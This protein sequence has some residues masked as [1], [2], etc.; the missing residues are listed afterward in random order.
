MQNAAQPRLVLPAQLLKALGQ[1]F[2]NM[3]GYYLHGGRWKAVAKHS[4]APKG[5]PVAHDHAAHQAA[6]AKHLSDEEW[7][8]L[9]L[10]A[11]NTNSGHYN[12]QLDKLKEWSEAG[13]GAAILG[14]SF[15]TNTYGKKLATVANHLLGKMGSQHK[16]APGQKAG[17]HAAVQAPAEPTTGPSIAELQQDGHLPA[18]EAA[19]AAKRAQNPHAALNEETIP[20]AP[21]GLSSSAGPLVQAAHQAAMKGD[22]DK[23]DDLMMQVHEEFNGSSTIAHALLGHLHDIKTAMADKAEFNAGEPGP[24]DGD[25]K[26]GANGSTLTF[27]D[28]RWHAKD[29]EPAAAP[30]PAAAEPAEPAPAAGLAM[31]EFQEGKTVTGVVAYYQ[32]VAQQ[33]IDH[34]EAGNVAVLEDMKAMGLKPNAKGKVSNTWAGKTP[35]SK[36][37]LALHKQALAHANGGA[38]Q[39][40]QSGGA[41]SDGAGASQPSPA[42]AAPAAAAADQEPVKNETQ[43]ATKETE[44]VAPPA[45]EPVKNDTGPLTAQQ[46]Q[47][48]QSIP[49]HKLK[50]PDSNTNAAS[51]NKKLQALQ[52]AAFAGDV[53]AIEAMTWGKNT[54]NKKLEL[55]AQTAVAALKEGA[56]PA[57]APTPA[58]ADAELA[59]MV[60][61][62]QQAMASE[63]KP[64]AATEAAT[65][66]QELTDM[67]GQAGYGIFQHPNKGFMLANKQGS[68][69]TFANWTQA[70][71]AAA[72]L[73]GLGLDAEVIGTYPYL[74]KVHGKVTGGPV[75]QA[76]APAP[77]AS[78]GQA[79]V[80]P[81]DHLAGLFAQS[82]TIAPDAL[83]VFKMV[84]EGTPGDAATVGEAITEVQKAGY[85]ESG[86][87]MFE[88]AAKHFGKAGPQEG[89]TKTEDGK[90]YKLI[91]GRWHLVSAEGGAPAK[92]N[93][94]AGSTWADYM[95]EIDAAIADNNI[96]PMQAVLT[97][98][99]G[100]PS[101]QAQKLKAYAEAAIAYTTEKFN[102]ELNAAAPAPAPAEAKHPV[103]EVPMPDLSG[104]TNSNWKSYASTAIEKLKAE[105]KAGNTDVLKG[106]TKKMGS[107]NHIINMPHPTVAGAKFK[108]KGGGKGAQALYEYVEAV[109]AAMGKPAKKK[110]APKAQT[111]SPAQSYG[112]PEAMDSWTQT[113]GQGGS[114]PG[115][116]FKDHNG[117]EWYCKFPGDDDVAKSEVLAAKLYAAAGLASQDAKLITKDGKL[118][119]ASKW[120]NV[121]KAGG[122][123]ELAKVDGALSGFAVD[124]WLGNWDV[125]GMALDNLQVGPDGKAMRVDA[126]GSLEYRAQGAKKP[127]GNE[128]TEMETLL[129]PSKNPHSAAVFGKMTEADKIASVAKVLQISDVAIRALVNQ[130]GPGD[131]AAKQKLAETLIARKADLAKKYPQA[132]KAKKAVV[133]KPEDISAPPSFTN[134]GGSGKSGPSSKEFVNL[135]NE[136]AVQ[137]IFATAKLGS[138]EAV[139]K[140]K[141]KTYDKSTGAVSGEAPVLEHPSQ[142]VKGYAQQVVN[143]INYQ[144]NPP[145]KFR[146][147]GG[148][149]LKALD[150]AYPTSHGPVSSPAVQ[151]LGKYVVLGEPGTIKVEDLSL[152]PEIKHTSAGGTLTTGT[153]AKTAQAV[154]AKMPKT[155]LQAIQAY[156]GSSY[157]EMNGSLWSGNPS[158]A[159]KSAGEALKTLGHDIEPGTILSRK[160]KSLDK[161]T[162]DQLMNSV[163]KVIQEP[164]IM[165]TS[166]RPSSWH[167]VVHL[168]LRV[169]P[170][171]KGLYVGPGSMPGGGAI[172]VNASEDEI[173]LPPN[174]RMLV[175]KASKGAQDKDGFGPGG[176]PIIECVILPT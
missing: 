65:K 48:L 47:A 49:W 57:P 130:F 170:G 44:P 66:L 27:K 24:K 135:A 167:G 162:I 76:P 152:P 1:K 77:E 39:P 68:L 109:K 16:V 81:A 10:P 141:A 159:A 150:S 118:G 123:A 31:P 73:A 134:W 160:L 84:T 120:V 99:A 83:E 145:K 119:I 37:L 59:Q 79:Q 51:V 43:A 18:A 4:P 61:A 131:A 169:G 13:H 34:A 88:L 151:K 70:S 80:T 30:A 97:L 110:A 91:N 129:D 52:D 96:A 144:L 111:M 29:D 46:L 132:Q 54:Y 25:T 8:Q 19:P 64:D 7:A 117:V 5:A 36:I 55:A 164:A 175:V 58:A 143:E 113:G 62:T 112:A 147:E 14:H 67:A 82:K 28:G 12:A 148:H 146:F 50:L 108:F 38:Q 128:V 157:H 53:A 63:Q 42:A 174:T 2:A 114:N 26:P 173:V 69:K 142:H 33:V 56:A 95:D 101:P 166:I 140:L 121:K 94:P 41:P 40:A 90:T 176:I 153:Y 136:E 104:A 138:I 122:A 89:G 9:K 149:P 127:F 21:S 156:T 161:S 133:F 78:A 32:K 74:V 107:G 158:G 86:K 125:V 11:E 105:L 116:K 168:K 71:N 15:G 171:V 75:A 23:I 106:I 22:A 20:P 3:P 60:S 137:S 115:G 85:I 45:A 93:M 163:G 35:N 165:S 124:A 6:P 102:A 92:P 72:K 155:Q 172:S 103:D 100:L 87:E 154:V 139:Q 98:T 126:G 17:Q